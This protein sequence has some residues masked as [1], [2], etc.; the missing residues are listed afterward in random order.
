MKKNQRVTFIHSTVDDAKGLGPS[1]RVMARNM[2][3]PDDCDEDDLPNGEYIG[4]GIF[5]RYGDE[6]STVIDD[7]CPS[8]AKALKDALENVLR[9]MEKTN[10]LKRISHE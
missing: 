4:I 2:F 10:K 6:W 9:D 7:I 3:T 8:A 5:Q 1:F